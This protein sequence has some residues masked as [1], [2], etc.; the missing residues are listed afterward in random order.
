V[1]LGTPAYTIFSGQMG[2]VDERLIA[3][4]RLIPLHDPDELRLVKRSSPEGIREPRD[5]EVLVDALLEAR[6]HR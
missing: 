5:P 1:A 6:S 2:A 3:E 4:G